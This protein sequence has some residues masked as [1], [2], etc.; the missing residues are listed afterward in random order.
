MTDGSPVLAI[1][2]LASTPPPVELPSLE[3]TLA[4]PGAPPGPEPGPEPRRRRGRPPG[5][6]T[7][8]RALSPG[9]PEDATGP[10]PASSGPRPEDVEAVSKA[11][12]LGFSI[13]SGMAAAKRGPHWHLSPEEADA[14]GTAWGT[15]LAPYLGAMAK[16]VP[17][18]TALVLTA[19]M[20][21]PRLQEDA[22]LA[23]SERRANRNPPVELD[24]D[25]LRKER[26]GA[27]AD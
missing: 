14:L 24:L 20:V 26:A 19:G 3:A 1:P 11:L 22:R 6:R 27:D 5:S 21:T 16:H 15:A 17:W 10:A 4:G 25:A 13:A 2:E 23:E 9:A 12:A 8:Q 18:V 7:R